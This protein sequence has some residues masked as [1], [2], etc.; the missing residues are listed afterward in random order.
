MLQKT[1]YKTCLNAYMIV[2]SFVACRSVCFVPPRPAYMVQWLD[3]LLLY[4]LLFGPSSTLR[5]PR[6]QNRKE[7]SDPAMLVPSTTF[8][9]NPQKKRRIV[10][11]NE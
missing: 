6:V 11:T 4:M 10:R 3:G 8:R 7:R 2:I 9:N 1:K 5:L